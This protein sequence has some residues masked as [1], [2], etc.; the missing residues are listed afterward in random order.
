[1]LKIFSL[2]KKS[3]LNLLAALL[4]LAVCLPGVAAAQQVVILVRHGEKL[5]DSADTILSPAG[6]ARA[7]RLAAVLA[8][9][10]LKAIYTSQY[11]RTMQQAAPIAAR[12]GLTPTVVA[13]KDSEALLAKIRTHAGNEAIL[14]VG[15]S[16]T[17]P[18]ILKGLGHS[19]ELLIADE[20]FDDLF[21]LVPQASGS[22][23][24]LRLKY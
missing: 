10:P 2:L 18:V 3:G 11:R 6:Q 7:N 14:V 19:P 23:L 4:V 17:L 21:L 9:T 1:V 24:L 15:H 16:N 13:A 22:P 20:A 8:D 12:Q 5:D